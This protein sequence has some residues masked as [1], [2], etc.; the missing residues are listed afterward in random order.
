M[1]KIRAISAI[2]VSLILVSPAKINAATSSSNVGTDLDVHSCTSNF[3]DNIMS[4]EKDVY[5]SHCIKAKCE[6]GTYD[7]EYYSPN[8]VNCLNGNKN[9][10]YEQHKSG[11]SKYNTSVCNSGE[12]KYCSIIMHYDCSRVTNGDPYQ[13]TTKKPVIKTTPKTTIVAKSNTK[14]KS[15]S[16]SEG[17]IPF[18]PNTYHY[19]IN[20]DSVI[21]S[22]NVNAVPEDSSS[23]VSVTGNT[24]LRDG[25]TI[26]ITVTGI[27]GSTSIY[28]VTIYKK[29]ATQLSNNTRLK[30]LKVEGYEIPF[31]PRTNS[32]M[33]TI[34]EGITKLNID[35]EPE[36]SS[37][38]VTI[39]DNE[40]L[41]TG[42]KITITVTAE[43]GTNGY[44]YINI[45]VQ[46]KSNF[47]KILFIIILILALL[48][49][50]YYIYKKFIQ[51]NGGEK[52][53]YE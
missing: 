37:S 42:S 47:I 36:D 24:D 3:Q 18:K 33:L 9:P 45:A 6:N 14:L 19:E 31:N 16:L 11:C 28:K 40:N 46:K 22:V 25:S 20:I 13:T 17:T 5:F 38:N 51:K 1:K 41:T 50:G 21:N 27:D 32:Y 8:K 44:Y 26:K 49:G 52:Y 7:L 2:L 35:Y 34:K 10:F 30:K 4:T 53:E 12:I 43:D 23:T 15:L 29:I 48:A 39:S